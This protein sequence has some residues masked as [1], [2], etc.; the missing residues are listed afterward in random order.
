MNRIFGAA[1]S[2]LLFG[3]GLVVAGMTDPQKIVGFLDVLGAWDPSLALV[4]GG[5]LAVT[6]ALFPLVIR[7]GAPLFDRQLRLPTRRDID[8]ALISG[9]ALFGIG[10][11]IAGY[12]PGPA[13]ASLGR[14][15]G[16]A[17]LFVAMMIAGMAVRRLLSNGA[18]AAREDA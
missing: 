5:A 11:G 8:V 17:A 2:G 15:V 7:R 13:L 1:L 16:A 9:S 6:A 18:P 3:F 4:M 12:C 14:P 10:W